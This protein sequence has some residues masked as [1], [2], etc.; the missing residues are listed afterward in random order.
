MVAR[1]TC[2]GAA[3]VVAAKLGGRPVLVRATFNGY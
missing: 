2:G 1:M 3:A